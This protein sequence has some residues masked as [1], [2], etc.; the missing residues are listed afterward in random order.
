MEL[1]G[2]A[3]EKYNL[4]DIGFTGSRFTWTN[5]QPNGNFT[6]VGLDWVMA[7]TQWCS[8]FTGANV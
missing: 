4:S 6:K 8:M 3:L 7:N 2:S 1:S 5:C